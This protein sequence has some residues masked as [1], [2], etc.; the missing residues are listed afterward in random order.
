MSN[1]SA[2]RPERVVE[3]PLGHPV[4]DLRQIGGERGDPF[5][6]EPHG[7]DR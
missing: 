1:R 3:P 4:R 6:V 2:R 7:S 5:V